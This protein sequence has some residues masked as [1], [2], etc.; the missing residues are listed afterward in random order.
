MAGPIQD[1]RPGMRQ[2]RL[3]EPAHKETKN[4]GGVSSTLP[5]PISTD[6]L[7]QGYL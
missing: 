4:P 7:S 5:F 3:A 2:L 1:F 6:P